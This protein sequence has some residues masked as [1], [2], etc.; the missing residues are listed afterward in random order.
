MAFNY[1]HELI[2]GGLTYSKYQEL[3]KATVKQPANDEAAEKMLPHVIKNL[4]LMM[5]YDES[6]HVSE[7]LKASIMASPEAIWLV[8]TEGWCGDAAFNVPMMAA[9]E[10][11]VP[12]KVQLRLF[13]A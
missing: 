5:Q 1:T 8:I 9:I 6:Y 10:K 4:E 13:F 11:A 2:N 3:I 12:A 7:E